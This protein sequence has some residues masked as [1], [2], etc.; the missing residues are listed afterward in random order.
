MKR[1][2]LCKNTKPKDRFIG[3]RCIRCDH[4]AAEVMADLRIELESAA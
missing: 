4:I 2:P 1:C 3:R